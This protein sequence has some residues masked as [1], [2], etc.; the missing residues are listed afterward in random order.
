MKRCPIRRLRVGRLFTLLSLLYFAF[1]LSSFT[2]QPPCR[3]PRYRPK[4]RK[5]LLLIQ[6]HADRL[7]MS[8]RKENSQY[9]QEM[10]KVPTIKN[11]QSRFL[12]VDL[13]RAP[14]MA[15]AAT[16]LIGSYSPRALEIAPLI[17][18]YIKANMKMINIGVSRPEVSVTCRLVWKNLTDLI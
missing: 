12:P 2:G 4:R 5:R 10:Q 13:K 9:L 16:E 8:M 14:V 17:P 18:L 1:S 11:K 15:P 3:M 7:E 6:Q